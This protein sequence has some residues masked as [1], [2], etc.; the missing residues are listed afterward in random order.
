MNVADVLQNPGGNFELAVHDDEFP[1]TAFNPGEASLFE[2]QMNTLMADL[3][4]SILSQVIK[5]REQTIAKVASFAKQELDGKVFGGINAGDNQ[6][7]FSVLRPGH[8]RADPSTGAAE[9]DWYFSPGTTGYVD[10]IGDGSGNNYSV[11]EDQVSVVLAFVDQD[12][13]TEVSALNVDEFGRNMDMLPHDLN[14]ARIMDN[15]NE[16]MV[17]NLPTLVAQDNDQIHAR[18]R[19][20]RDVES[21]PRFFGFTFALGGFL[22]EEDY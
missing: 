1:T 9:N 8:I 17:K 20:D 5:Q 16:I 7:G 13:S 21:Q 2:N 12:V 3:D 14:D 10:W 19:Y 18:L 15:E 4:S 11:G 22:N 6:I